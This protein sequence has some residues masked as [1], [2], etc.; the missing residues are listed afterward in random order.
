MKKH[1]RIHKIIRHGTDFSILLILFLLGFGA[2]L[3][4]QHQVDRQILVA[5]LMSVLYALWGVIHHYHED[6]LTFEVGLEY[7][8]VASLVGFILIIFLLRA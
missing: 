8:G 3:F 4:Y 6:N 2:L 5:V 7:I 1:H